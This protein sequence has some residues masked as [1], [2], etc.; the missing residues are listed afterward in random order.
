MSVMKAREATA[1]PLGIRQWTVSLRLLQPGPPVSCPVASS[2][3][4]LRSPSRWQDGSLQGDRFSLSTQEGHVTLWG[5]C[6]SRPPSATGHQALPSHPSSA[7]EW[8]S[9]NPEEVHSFNK[10]WM[11]EINEGRIIFLTW[12]LSKGK[13]NLTYP[14]PASKDGDRSVALSSLSFASSTTMKC[15]IFSDQK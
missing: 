4:S 8:T 6:T 7:D 12:F 9:F 2:W 3:L 10:H 5:T 11:M 13:G 14:S 1:S 15:S